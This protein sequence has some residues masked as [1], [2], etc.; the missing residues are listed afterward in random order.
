MGDIGNLF[1]FTQDN[2]WQ[3]QKTKVSGGFSQTFTNTVTRPGTKIVNGTST[4]IYRESDP[5]NTRTP[6]ETYLVKDKS[7]I[8]VHGNDD[9]TD[10]ITPLITPYLAY[11]FPLGPGSVLPVLSNRRILVNNL[12]FDLTFTLTVEDFESVTVPTGTFSNALKVVTTQSVVFASTGETIGT[13]TATDWIVPGIGFV[14]SIESSQGIGVN[15]RSTSVLTAYNVDGQQSGGG[16]PPPP[17]PTSIE[18][19]T[20]V[21]SYTAVFLNQTKQLTAVAFSQSTVPV[22]GLAYTWHSTD[23]AIVEVDGNGLITGRSPGKATITA[24][25][26]GLTSNALTYTVNNGKL[27]SL[28]TNDLAYDKVSQKIYASIRSD[29]AT[30]PDT[31]TV[32][33]PTTGNVGPFVPVGVQPNK[34]AVSQDGQ[35]LYVGLDGV[36]AV[37][38]TQLPGLI[39][40]PTFSLGTGAMAGC[41]TAPLVVDDMEVVP[42][43]PLSVAVARKYT[44]GCSPWHFGVA[45]FDDGIQRPAITPARP[46]ANIIEFSGSSATLY[47]LDGESDASDFTTIGVDSSGAT[48]QKETFRPFSVIGIRNDM[49][50]ESGR[51]YTNDGEVLDPVTGTRLGTYSRPSPDIVLSSVRPDPVLNKVFFLGRSFTTGTLHLLAYDKTTTQLLGTEEI[52]LANDGGFCTSGLSARTELYRWGTDGLAFRTN[53]CHVVL[54]H[55]TLVR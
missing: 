27:I 18:I 34:L 48:I 10:D 29:S 53:G 4:I 3:Y 28:V 16:P 23:P 22:T 13:A 52:D 12:P 35:F 20:P 26:N 50:F 43:F 1:P 8:T 44:G 5:E 2:S 54:L 42:G 32:I 33:D 14:K 6:Q 40:G 51:I 25:A 46:L 19:S 24:T 49:V 39:P 38:R 55:S 36:G 11:Q 47:G 30:N 41:P 7:G 45:V 31:I 37:R 21:G 17:I 15:E 9:A